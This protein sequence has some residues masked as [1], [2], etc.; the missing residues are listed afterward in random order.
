[1]GIYPIMLVFIYQF[2]FFVV[3]IIF[4]TIYNTPQAILPAVAWS[5]GGYDAVALLCCGLVLVGVMP[6][7]YHVILKGK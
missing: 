7:G 1:M 2:P 4:S 6:F 3:S 5:Y